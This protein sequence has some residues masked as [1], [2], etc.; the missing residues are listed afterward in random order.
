MA[1]EGYGFNTIQEFVG[2]ELRPQPTLVISGS[3]DLIVPLTN[4]RIL[5]RLIPDFRLHGVDDGHLALLTSAKELAP[6]V[7]RFLLEDGG[8]GGKH[9]HG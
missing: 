4:A 1:L 2:R 3:E 7:K 8:S 5:A 9:A 6:V